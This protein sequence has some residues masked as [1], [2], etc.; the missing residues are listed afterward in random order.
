MAPNAIGKSGK[1]NQNAVEA[2]AL[3]RKPVQ[4]QH[5]DFAV[6]GNPSDRALAKVQKDF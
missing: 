2:L 1:A 4:A 5:V 3:Q 6:A